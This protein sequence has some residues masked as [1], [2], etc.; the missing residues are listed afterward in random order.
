MTKADRTRQA[1]D[2]LKH[3]SRELLEL[4]EYETMLF[5]IGDALRDVMGRLPSEKQRRKLREVRARM[6]ELFGFFA[7]A[8][9]RE[10][11]ETKV[12]LA[13][14]EAKKQGC[15]VCPALFEE[16]GEKLNISGDTARGRYYDLIERCRELGIAPPFLD[17]ENDADPKPYRLSGQEI[18][19]LS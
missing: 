1:L 3:A 17:Q 11:E 4:G 7:D 14:E 9:E 8:A 2:A 15:G 12:F 5:C 18:D 19:E 16:I 13:V 6:S 10:L